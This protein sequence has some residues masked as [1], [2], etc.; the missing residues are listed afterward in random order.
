MPVILDPRL[1]PLARS[2]AA[3]GGGAAAPV[4]DE[5]LEAFPVSTRVNNVRNDVAELIAPMN[6]A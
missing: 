3:E 5:W 6:P 4:P 2:G 1:R